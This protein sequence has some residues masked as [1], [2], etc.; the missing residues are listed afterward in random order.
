MATS[1]LLASCAK[2]SGTETPGGSELIAG[3]IVGG[4]N[5]TAAFQKENGVVALLIN[6]EDG[7]GLCT[8]T[9]ISKKIVLTAAHCLD[10]SGSAI[11]SISVIFTQDVSKVAQEN[12]RHGVKSQIHELFLTTAGS[13]GSWN[14]I[15][16]IK[17]DKDAPTGV[18]FAK[19]PSIV[20]IPLKTKTPIIQAG[21]GRQEATRMPASDTS[22]VLKKVSG[23]EVINVVQN[24]Q[25]LLL[26]ED[27]KG[28]CNGDSGGPAFT[29][30]ASGR[31]TQ[32]GINSRGTDPYSCIGVGVFTSVAAHLDWIR[33]NSDLLMAADTEPPTTN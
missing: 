26:K 5:A 31:L 23:I 12:I 33:I 29:K 22:G 9:L 13:Q 17:L 28:S 32:V 20:S 10:N 15:A 7:E 27:G 25:E 4:A 8:G 3:N 30:S 1:L 14:D 19:L 6:T 2:D 16:L 24:G 11:K 18:K 21:F